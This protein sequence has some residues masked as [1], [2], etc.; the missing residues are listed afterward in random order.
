MSPPLLISLTWVAAFDKRLCGAAPG[1]CRPSSV[2]HGRVRSSCAFRSVPLVNRPVHSHPFVARMHSLPPANQLAN[3]YQLAKTAIPAW[4][5]PG[6]PESY[7]QHVSSARTFSKTSELFGLRL[8]SL[9][10]QFIDLYRNPALKLDFYRGSSNRA[11]TVQ[12][13]SACHSG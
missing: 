3:Y 13:L 1:I 5:S 6:F 4:S 11:A 9:T 12:I 7:H 8:L 10:H 2:G